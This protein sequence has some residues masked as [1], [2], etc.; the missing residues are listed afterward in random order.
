MKDRIF[1]NAS[2]VLADEVI[3]GGTVLANEDGSI[4]EISERPTDTA[5]AIDC[6]GDYLIPG[7]IELHTDNLEKHT[8]PRP[9][10]E[11]PS[12]AAVVAHDSQLAAAGITT[13]FDAIALGSVVETS[14]RC[15]VS[16]D[17]F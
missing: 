17:I 16:H 6:G 10:T 11:W 14:E 5:D 13:V 1:T 4:R 9:K 8:T 3:E 15:L 2:V 12:L 7:L